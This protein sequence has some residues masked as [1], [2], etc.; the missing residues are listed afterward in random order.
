MTTVFSGLQSQ[1]LGGFLTI[2]GYATLRDLARCSYADPG[3]QR[4]LNAAH[5]DD[6]AAFVEAGEYLFFPEIVL[7]AE[8]KVDYERPNPVAD[9]FGE[10]L[11]REYFT[12]NVDDLRVRTFANRTDIVVPDAMPLLR[13]ID[14]NHRLAAIEALNDDRYDRFVA[15]FCILLFAGG[16][17]STNEK[18]LF[19]NINSKARALTPEESLRGIID[20]AVAF[21][22]DVLRD[23]FGAGYLQCRRF[24]PRLDF[25]FLPHLRR[26]FGQ[27][28]G[29]TS[30]LRSVLLAAIETLMQVENASPTDDRLLEGIRRLDATYAD[31]RLERAEAA[32]L[33]TAFLYYA[34]RSDDGS[35]ARFTSWV[36]NT[37]QYE[38][39]SIH[40]A[41][42]IKI[43]DK[44]M[45][46][47]RR[48]LFIS[49]WFA[50]KTRPNWEAIKAAVDELNA[51]HPIDIRLREIR[52]DQF[53]TGYSYE[54]THEIL[55]LIEDSGL[56]I[57]DL[58]GGNKNVHHEVGYLMGL[59]RGRGRPHDNFL[60]L[61]NAQMGDPAVDIGFN[62]AGIKQLRVID[63][64]RLREEVKHQVA[65]FYGLAM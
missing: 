18:A 38:H 51:A 50:D 60:L 28:D 9:P 7:S 33:F 34:V 14:G 11:R 20:D 58:T 62:L 25:A 31:P 15:P 47:R 48:Q 6:I 3:Y 54:I 35:Y 55:Q 52:I 16:D 53:D 12:S 61:H 36:F 39:E 17:A 26:V 23:R 44:V 2:R 57:A 32:G 19:H 21:P 43:F 37:H 63:T 29:G 56:L 27:Q 22:D 1:S 45:T 30:R 64:N 13:R 5:R 8:L 10:I 65:I 24:I 42:L 46:S 4:D 59:N 40:A 49:M 41:D